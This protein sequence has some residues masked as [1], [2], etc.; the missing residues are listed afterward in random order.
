M[1]WKMILLMPVKEHDI[2]A[3]WNVVKYFIS[4]LQLFL[5]KYKGKGW[6]NNVLYFLNIFI[7]NIC[8]SEARNKVEKGSLK[9]EFR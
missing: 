1:V 5:K 2:Y 8:K 6:Y 3:G 7:A 9:F 4:F